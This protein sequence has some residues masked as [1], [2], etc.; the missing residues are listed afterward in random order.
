MSRG[1]GLSDIVEFKGRVE[2]VV[3]HLN[4]A[5]AFVLSSR[6]EGFGL[7]V[8]EAMACELPVVST[9]AGGPS[10][11]IEEGQTGHLARRGSAADLSEKLVRVMGMSSEEREVLGNR[12]RQ[13]IQNRYSV[14]QMVQRWRDIFERYC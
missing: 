13:R 5:D 8:A 7:V 10:E 1:L 11:I 4:N 14:E 3:E 2:S 6:W 12:G 9:D